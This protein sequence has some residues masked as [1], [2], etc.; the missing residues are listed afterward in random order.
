MSNNIKFSD[1]DEHEVG[2]TKTEVKDLVDV[3][4]RGTD[5]IFTIHGEMLKGEKKTVRGLCVM[6]VFFGV[7]DIYI[8]PDRIAKSFAKGI[9]IGGNKPAL[10]YKTAV[11]AV[12]AHELQHANQYLVHDVKSSAFFGKTRSKY[13]ARA[14]EREARNFADENASIIAEVIGIHVS[15]PEVKDIAP[16]ELIQV[17]ESLSGTNGITMSDI[18]EELRLSGLN[19]AVNFTIVKNILIKSGNLILQQGE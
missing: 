9:S 16:D 11:A 4:Y 17:A 2:L 12:L 6:D 13:R 1:F 10:S 7:I 5:G 3:L 18:V 14:S 15:K 19:N 8:A